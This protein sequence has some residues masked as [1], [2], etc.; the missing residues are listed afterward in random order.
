[1]GRHVQ[2]HVPGCACTCTFACVDSVLQ[3]QS[4][5]DRFL[6]VHT[7]LNDKYLVQ[8]ISIWRVGRRTSA[9]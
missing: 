6:V 8:L 1:M 3:L 2:I 4:Y 7:V 9:A 5:S